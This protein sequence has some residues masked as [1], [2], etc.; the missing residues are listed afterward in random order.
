[1]PARRPDKA[2]LA[3]TTKKIEANFSNF[4]AWHQRTKVIGS[5][6]ASGEIDKASALQKGVH[7]IFFGCLHTLNHLHAEFE[8]VQNAMFTL[9]EDQSAWLY[10]RWLIGSGRS[11]I[12]LSQWAVDSI[13]GQE[14]TRSYSNVRSRSS[15]RS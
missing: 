6:W 7:V 11:L 15:R 1:M 4:S 13:A 2:E 12:L 5:L 8:L 9:P 10:H 14:M 3:Y